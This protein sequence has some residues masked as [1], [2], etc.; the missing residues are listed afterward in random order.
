MIAFKNVDLYHSS[1]ILCFITCQCRKQDNELRCKFDL[2]QFS[3]FLKKKFY[4]LG[5]EREGKN[6]NYHK[7]NFGELML[8]ADLFH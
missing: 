1:S 6:I 3:I 2:T 4:I 5:A 7:S 8:L